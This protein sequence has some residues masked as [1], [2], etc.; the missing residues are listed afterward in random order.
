M[1]REA[2]VPLHEVAR[3]DSRTKAR[4]SGVSVARHTRRRSAPS[5]GGRPWRWVTIL[6]S[7]GDPA[8]VRRISDLPAGQPFR[9][10]NLPTE[11][12]YDGEEPGNPGE[13]RRRE[14]PARLFRVE[15]ISSAGG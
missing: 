15:P 7:A 11:I 9:V 8:D 2:L 4:T 14:M 6:E 1:N 12:I 10:Q 13:L 3:A 5:R